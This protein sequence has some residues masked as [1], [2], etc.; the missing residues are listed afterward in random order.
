M[1]V[2]PTK[3]GINRY[4]PI[5]ISVHFSACCI[6]MHRAKEWNGQSLGISGKGF[7]WGHQW[8][9]LRTTGPKP[10]VQI[11]HGSSSFWVQIETSDIYAHVALYHRKPSLSNL[12]FPGFSSPPATGLA[13]CR[14]KTR[15]G[16]L[17]LQ[18]WVLGEAISND[19]VFDC[20]RS[21]ILHIF[22]ADIF[23]ISH[24]ELYH[25]PLL[26][27]PRANRA[28]CWGVYGGSEQ[29]DRRRLRS[30]WRRWGHRIFEIQRA[31]WAM[32]HVLIRLCQSYA[33]M[34]WTPVD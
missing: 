17:K 29:R 19:Q 32:S 31:T 6:E 9:D 34:D 23:N 20:C 24:T 22:G 8:Q 12:A 26:L 14:G 18:R 10:T 33:G 13:G 30:V 11:A 25:C 5:P 27:K 15:L 2:H 4:W 7:K 16:H 1:D 28:N 21:C 3:N